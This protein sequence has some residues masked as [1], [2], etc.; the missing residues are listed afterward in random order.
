[1]YSDFEI[2]DSVIRPFNFICPFAAYVDGQF[3]S[4]SPRGNRNA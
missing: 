4:L 3:T 2:S 1:M